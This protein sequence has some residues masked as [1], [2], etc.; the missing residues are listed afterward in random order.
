MNTDLLKLAFLFL[1]VVWV[2]SLKDPTYLA[3]LFIFLLYL[4]VITKR[5]KFL[6]ISLPFALMYLAFHLLL[7]QPA[8]YGIAVSLRI[9]DLS[10]LSVVAFRFINLP[11]AF[12]FSKKLSFLLVSTMV[13]YKNII[14]L[15]DD[16]QTAYSSRVIEGLDWKKE[17]SRVNV[18]LKV[19][20]ERLSEDTRDAQ[21]G[22][23]SR[24][25]DL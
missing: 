11:K 3:W 9:L 5:L 8:F 25:F 4:S 13:Y 17:L 16:L 2:S 12:S 20:L 1:V 10:L 14:Q 19:I 7:E 18:W 22:I 23:R 24:W 6:L 21:D 15:K